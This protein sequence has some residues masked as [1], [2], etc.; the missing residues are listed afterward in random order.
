ML[1]ETT[2]HGIALHT[3]SPGPQ[4]G[5]GS[6]QRCTAPSQTTGALS[7]RLAA[8]FHAIRA[9]ANLQIPDEIHAQTTAIQTRHPSYWIV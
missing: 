6:P 7:K 8:V 2:L 3:G 9:F 4:S 5:H 1:H